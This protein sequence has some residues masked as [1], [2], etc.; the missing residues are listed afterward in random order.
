MDATLENTPKRDNR[1]RINR[2]C[3]GSA[4]SECRGF[5]SPGSQPKLRKGRAESEEPRLAIFLAAQPSDWRN[6]LRGV[7]LPK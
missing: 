4:Y 7:L 1:P 2:V 6:L 3:H 5:D